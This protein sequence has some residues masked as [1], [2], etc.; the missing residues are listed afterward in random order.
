MLVTRYSTTSAIE[1][2]LVETAELAALAAENMISTYTLTIAEI[3][4]NPTLVDDN[5]SKEKK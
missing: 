3:A 2:N 4:S 5:I 1:K